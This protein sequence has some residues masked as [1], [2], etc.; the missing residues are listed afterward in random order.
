MNSVQKCIYLV[1]S[2]DCLTKSP[3]PK[4]H[5]KTCKYRIIHELIDEN[6]R[7]EKEL[8]DLKEVVGQ[9]SFEGYQ[10]KV[11]RNAINYCKREK[12]VDKST[13]IV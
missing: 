3:E 8:R 10:P 5:D 11:V 2:C 9:I 4:Y 7:L 12:D 13:N 6:E 1:G